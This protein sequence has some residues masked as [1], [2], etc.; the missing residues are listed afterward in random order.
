MNERDYLLSVDRKNRYEI[1]PGFEPGSSEFQLDALTT[2]L[3]ELSGIGAENMM[4]HLDS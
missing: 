4:F 3:L 2:E 1:Q